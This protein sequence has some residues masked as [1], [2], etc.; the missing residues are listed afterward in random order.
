MEFPGGEGQVPSSALPGPLP[1]FA[2]ANLERLCHPW[3]RGRMMRKELP[4]E[5]GTEAV[6]VGSCRLP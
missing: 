3:G 2:P 5:V 1:Q 4:L 6:E